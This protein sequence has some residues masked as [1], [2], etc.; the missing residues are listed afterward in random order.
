[1]LM[2]FFG[3]LDLPDWM[4]VIKSEKAVGSVYAIL[5][6]RGL[7]GEWTMPP[8][9]FPWYSSL[10]STPPSPDA[11]RH[12]LCPF[13]FSALPCAIG[14]RTLRS[15]AILTPRKPSPWYS[16]PAPCGHIKSKS[17]PNQTKQ[18]RKPQPQPSPRS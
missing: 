15:F 9:I 10:L 3:F 12:A 8:L 18:G 16:D 11:F 14:S 1:M 2:H 13:P 5:L 17:N 7:K 6:V 4:L